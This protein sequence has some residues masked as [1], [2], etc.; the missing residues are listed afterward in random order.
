MESK[1]ITVCHSSEESFQ[2]A[3]LQ[4]P[5]DPIRGEMNDSRESFFADA[6]RFA[7]P[8]QIQTNGFNNAAFSPKVLHERNAEA[9]DPL[10]GGDRRANQQLLKT[11][12]QDHHS[13]LG[14]EEWENRSHQDARSEPTGRPMPSQLSPPLPPLR[15]AMKSSSNDRQQGE[16][17]ELRDIPLQPFFPPP[18]SILYS[19]AAPMTQNT[20]IGITSPLD[21][22]SGVVPEVKILPPTP[23][24]ATGTHVL[25]WLNSPTRK[26]TRHSDNWATPAPTPAPDRQTP[27]TSSLRLSEHREALSNEGVPI[28]PP[29]TPPTTMNPWEFSVL[30]AAQKYDDEVTKGWK[31]DIDN[32]LVFV[33]FLTRLGVRGNLL[34]FDVKAGLFSGV[35]TAFTIQ[36]FHWLSEDPQVIVITLLSQ[37][38]RQLPN[39]SEPILPSPPF[40]VF[41]PSRTSV[42][43]INSFWFLSIVVS[44]LSAFFGILCKQWLREHT[45]DT[46]TR[47]RAEALALRQLRNE[48]FEKWG[49]SSIIATLPVLLEISLLLFFA[50]VLELLWTLHKV[51][52]ATAAAAVG[53]GGGLYLITTLLPALNIIRV[54]ADF[55]HTD[56]RESFARM[57]SFRFICPYKSPQ[58]WGLFCVTRKLLGAIPSFPSLSGRWHWRTPNLVQKLHRASHWPALD[59]HHVRRFDE[60]PLHFQNLHSENTP[61]A[62]KDLKVYELEGLRGLVNMFHDIPSMRPHLQKLLL[63]FEPSVVMA[64]VFNEWKIGTWRTSPVT[65]RDVEASL[66]DL[67]RHTSHFTDEKL[68]AGIPLHDWIEDW[69]QPPASAESPLHSPAFVELLYFQQYWRKALMH[70][71]LRV[72]ALEECTDKF[73]SRVDVLQK[74]GFWFPIPFNAMQGLWAHPNTEIRRKS[75]SF[76]KFYKKGWERYG[77]EEREDERFALIAALARHILNAEKPH[78]R[79]SELV[80]S[81]IGLDL[82]RLINEDIVSKKLFKSKRYDTHKGAG[83]MRDWVKAISLVKERH[84]SGFSR[85]PIFSATDDFEGKAGT[86]L[87]DPD[88][89]LGNGSDFGFRD[90]RSDVESRV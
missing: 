6:S 79:K 62:G 88:G 49:V 42:V 38:S 19:P 29:P 83:G 80:W 56:G 23:A 73:F 10:T 59:L 46:Q 2:T 28:E 68:R 3:D 48:S 74:T 26:R 11:G 53:L 75:I 47:S 13:D 40:G 33:G 17:S 8:E 5:I 61:L 51:P 20:S 86:E 50:G 44:L 58:A 4:L 21:H 55:P 66:E 27:G 41:S 67:G 70:H 45:R 18:S 72:E 22:D 15:S 16:L 89:T 76:V 35:V 64:A 24:K 84:S 7:S 71:D 81:D 52:F 57:P 32:L 87:D 12:R 78:G 1:K 63:N 9:Y 65:F 34:I 69:S 37:I 43:R 77:N 30:Q 14:Y 54:S 36:A 31:D 90:V 60:N 39:A 25:P 82:L 85:I